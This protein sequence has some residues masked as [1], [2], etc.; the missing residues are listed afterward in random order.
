MSVFK[1]FLIEIIISSFNN[2]ALDKCPNG[3]AFLNIMAS[4]V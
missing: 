4:S 1:F 3:K 2:N